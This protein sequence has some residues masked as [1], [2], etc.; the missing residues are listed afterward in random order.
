LSP[1]PRHALYN[2]G[3]ETLSLGELA[4]IVKGLIPGADIAFEHETGGEEK[5]GAYLFDNDRLVTE[6]GIQYLPYRQRVAR[7]I[8]S[9]RCGNAWG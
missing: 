7:M 5:S 9:V 8:D 4:A 2:T 3:G 1:K 6:F